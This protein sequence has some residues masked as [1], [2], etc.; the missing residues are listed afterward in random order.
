MAGFFLGTGAAMMAAGLASSPLALGVALAAMGS[1]AAIYHPIG[2][3]M[4]V[5]AAGDRVGRSVGINGVF[6]NLGVACAPVGAVQ[7]APNRARNARSAVTAARVG[8]WSSGATAASASASS[9][10]TSIAIAPWLTSP[11][12]G[13]SYR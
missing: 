2:T 10:R 5:E 13:L 7:P 4:L 6:G 11:V 12:G 1:F 3:A 9:A 8:A